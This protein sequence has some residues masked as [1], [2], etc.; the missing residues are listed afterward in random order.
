MGARPS[1][2]ELLDYLA[3]RLVENRWSIKSIQREI[4][5]TTSVYAL[6]S[7]DIP[8]NATRSDPDNRFFWRANWQR[9]DAETLRDSLLFVAGNLDLQ[10]GGPP[11]PLAEDNHRRTVYGF[12]S[13][14]K[15]DPMLTLFD[16]PNPNTTSEQRVVTSTPLQRLYMINSSFV[17]D[18]AAAL[19]KGLTG[20]DPER[21]GR[22]YRVLFARRP[23]SRELG[24]ALA[25]LQKNTWK[26]YARV[27]LNSNEFLFV[28]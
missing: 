2:Q 14:R 7:A 18:Q 27:L 16:F 17:E 1:N 12:V 5:L 19:A 20:N 15:L 21:V 3:A 9:M 22:I 13:R 24:L 28:N 8:S 23:T 25:F 6:S 26:E 10:M 11:V 4:M